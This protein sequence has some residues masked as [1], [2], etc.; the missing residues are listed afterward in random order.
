MLR[1]CLVYGYKDEQLQCKLLAEK[2]LTFQQALI[3]AKA[4]EATAKG[5]KDLQ[6]HTTH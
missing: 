1:D 6:Q 2:N 5:I 3:I 4:T